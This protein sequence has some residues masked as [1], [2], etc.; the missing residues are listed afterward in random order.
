MDKLIKQLE[1]DIIDCRLDAGDGGN[2]IDGI[3][4]ALE[5]LENLKSKLKN[6]GGLGN[7][8]DCLHPYDDVEQNDLGQMVC[9]CGKILSQ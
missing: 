8:S 7:V 2:N 3:S 4:F 9:K 6:N 1:Q 5:T